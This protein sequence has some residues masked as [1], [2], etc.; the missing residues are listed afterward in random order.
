MAKKTPYF[1]PDHEIEQVFAGIRDTREM[2]EFFQEIFT[3][4]E[5][6]DL[7]LRWQLLKELY[8]GNPQRSIAEKHRISLCKITRGSKILKGDSSFT[9][10]ILDNLYREKKI[11][12]R[13]KP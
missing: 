1:D 3:P 4:K 2:I 8:E 10:R 5:I 6:S 12:R 11:V 13:K 9:R 7:T